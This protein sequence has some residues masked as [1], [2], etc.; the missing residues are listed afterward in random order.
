MYR[1]DVFTEFPE[2][3]RVELERNKRIKIAYLHHDNDASHFVSFYHRHLALLR[4]GE[5]IS[6]ELPEVPGG[7]RF[8]DHM[9]PQLENADVIILFLSIDFEGDEYRNSSPETIALIDACH[10]KGTRV[11]KV[12]VKPYGGD[13]LFQEYGDFLGKGKAIASSQ[14]SSSD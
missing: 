13:S 12:L 3:R 8:Q 6:D 9:K 2:A 4:R 10:K 1:M 11:W 14:S 5:K 7:T